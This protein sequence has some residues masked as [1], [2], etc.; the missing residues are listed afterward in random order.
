MPVH[1]TGMKAI[2]E[3]QQTFGDRCIIAMAGDVFRDE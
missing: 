1:C 3:M 2:C